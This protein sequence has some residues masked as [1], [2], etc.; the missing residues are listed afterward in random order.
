MIKVIDSWIAQQQQLKV[1]LDAEYEKKAQFA[2]THKKQVI[3]LFCWKCKTNNTVCVISLFCRSASLCSWYVAGKM[4]LIPSRQERPESRGYRWTSWKLL[5]L[6]S[7]L[8]RRM[9][10]LVSGQRWGIKNGC[11]LT[12]FLQPSSSTRPLGQV[13]GEPCISIWTIQGEVNSSK[14]RARRMIRS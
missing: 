11:G 8:Y 14:E 5:G 6:L 4:N 1:S 3:H 2:I 7:T 10:Y 9:Q 12:A 13:K